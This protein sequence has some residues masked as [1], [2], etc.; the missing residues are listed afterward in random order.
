VLV[1]SVVA[2]VMSVVP[3]PALIEAVDNLGCPTASVVPQPLSTEVAWCS[4]SSFTLPV[5]MPLTAR[6]KTCSTPCQRCCLCGGVYLLVCVGC[7]LCLWVCVSPAVR[8]CVC[9]FFPFL[10][11]CLCVCVCWCVDVVRVVCVSVCRF[12]PRRCQVPGRPSAPAALVPGGRVPEH[13]LA[14]A[15]SVREEEEEEEEE[16][17]RRNAQEE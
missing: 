10:W 7:S 2:N 5:E 15:G 9:V 3:L 12:I 13:S 16:T 11:L 6:M 17:R 14:G 4:N 8:V 1:M